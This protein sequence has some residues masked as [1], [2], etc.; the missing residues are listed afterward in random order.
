MWAYTRSHSAG[1]KRAIY[2]GFPSTTYTYRL[3][4][5]KKGEFTIGPFLYRHGNEEV[6]VPA[7]MDFSG[8][9]ADLMKFIMPARDAV[10]LWWNDTRGK[11]LGIKLTFKKKIKLG[12]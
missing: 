4:P 11:D 9:Y 1:S 3:R 2:N 7:I 12:M 8:P 10:G 5:R 6:E